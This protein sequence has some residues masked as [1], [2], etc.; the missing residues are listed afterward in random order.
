MSTN[1]IMIFK[2]E[3]SK[4]GVYFNERAATRE[5][6]SLKRSPVKGIQY[7]VYNEKVVGLEFNA[8]KVVDYKVIS[9]FLV[10]Y[11]RLNEKKSEAIMDTM[12]GLSGNY[13]YLLSDTLH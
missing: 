4:L 1:F 5:K 7:A 8:R 2:P 12:V 11:L 3:K 13:H 6:Y 10:K 9:D